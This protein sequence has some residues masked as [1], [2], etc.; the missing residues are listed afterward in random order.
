MEATDQLVERM[1]GQRAETTPWLTVER[2]AYLAVGLL[3]ALLRLYQLGLRPLGESE[4]VQSLAAFRFVEG[5]GQTAPAGTVPALFTGNVLGFTLMGSSDIVARWLP[6]A[7]GLILVLLPYALRH[8]LGRGGALASSLLLAISPSMVFFSRSVD[9][10]ILVACCG[11]ALVVGLI[12][13]LDT[14]RPLF[15]YGAAVALGVGLTAGA[16]IYT[17]ILII[18]AFGFLLY[19]SERAQDHETGWSSLVVAWWAMRDEKGLLARSGA[20]LAVTL[21]LVST[22]AVLYPAGLGHT[23]DLIGTW[24]QSFLPG[25][26]E[27]PLIYPVLLLLRYELLIVLLGL[28]ELV[29]GLA[30]GRVGQRDVAP[31]GS[32]FPHTAFLGFWALAAL[33][34]VFVGGHRSAGNLLLVVIPLALLAGQGI[35]K[36]WHWVNGRYLWVGAVGF[37]AVAVGLLA[38]FYLQLASYGLTNNSTVSTF[39]GITFY[40]SVSYLLLGLMALLFLGGL[41]V[42]AVIW[43]GRELVLAGGWL[44]VLIIFGLFG[45]KAMWGLN[46]ARASDARELMLLQ[47][48]APDVRHLVGRLEAL[49]RELQ[50]D[51]HTL[52]L[53]TDAATGPVVGWY[54]RD[55]DRQIVVEDLDTPPDTLAAV[56]LAAQ[57]LP[58]GETFRGQSFPL[59]THWLPWGLWEQDL[60]RWLLFTEGSLPTVDQEVVLWVS[61]DR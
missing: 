8:R 18:A 44:A 40:N 32:S 2:A 6:A 21:G 58:I 5:A 48:T 23:A 50:G 11:L 61:S 46:F 30:A 27:Q 33:L 52:A 4:A 56:T 15:L 1:E 41:V 54:L 22:V 38:F 35:E 49:S 9:S 20:V 10:A 57:D 19:V 60:V 29:R 7:A 39:A 14:R 59:R 53:T 45:F 34:I 16:G 51:A 17:M 28:V 3:A 26:G 24:V 25:T 31:F 47:A 42:A 12:N 36:A 55:F 37:A 13:Y 43:Q